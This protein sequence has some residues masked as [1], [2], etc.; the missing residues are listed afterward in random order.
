MSEAAFLLFIHARSTPLLDGLFRV[1]HEL[2]TLT[3]CLVLVLGAIAWHS[4]HGGRR[5]A[6]AWLVVGLSTLLLY[7]CL[8]PAFGR[9]RPGL[10]PPLVDEQGYAFP[11]GHALASATFY[12][13][14]AWTTLRLRGASFALFSG[15]LPLFI[16]F[17]RLY[18]GVHWP[19]DVLAGWALG[20]AQAAAAI[21]WLRPERP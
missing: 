16:G 1:S 12:P 13:L 19:T 6:V 20:A 15:A 9:S 3:A 10:W 7:V 21:R 8:K 18:L 5:E 14:L 11:S 17:G 2:G 4:A